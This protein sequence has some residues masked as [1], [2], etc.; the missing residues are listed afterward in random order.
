MG[1]KTK[2]KK[3]SILRV[4]F[5]VAILHDDDDDVESIIRDT[6][7][8]G[9]HKDVTFISIRPLNYQVVTNKQK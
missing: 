7:F 3:V 4:Q 8:D 1:K 6:D 5:S 9:R 2:N